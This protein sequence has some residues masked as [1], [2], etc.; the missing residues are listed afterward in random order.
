MTDVR[1]SEA[2]PL[3]G[4][5]RE[6]M[7]HLGRRSRVVDLRG[8][9]SHPATPPGP[10]EADRRH[11]AFLT[12]MIAYLCAD[13]GVAQFV[14]WGS[15]VPG[16]ADLVRAARPD[17]RVVHV[18]PPGVAGMVASDAVLTGDGSC[19]PSSLNRL[20]TSGLVD[21]D[22]PVAV[23]MTRPF[24]AD[25][26]PT[27]IA[28]LHALMRG[29]GYLALTTTGPHTALR[30]ALAP[31]HPVEPGAADI[32]WWPYPDEDVPGPGTGTLGALG[33]ASGR[34]GGGRRWRR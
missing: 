24:A 28:D 8:L 13:G 32:Q 3:T 1:G 18:S 25:A 29:G 2:G 33:R 12:R 16:T 34:T 27:G 15:P 11:G 21:L 17:A 22:E 7:R 23:L 5:R 19:S 30:S 10:D 4:A 6:P 31:F 9:P 20:A 14:D 26:P